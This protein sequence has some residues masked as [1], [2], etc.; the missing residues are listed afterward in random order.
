MTSNALI[1]C[2]QVMERERERESITGQVERGGRESILVNWREGEGRER[3]G[4]RET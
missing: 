4:E 1:I 3:D 2:K